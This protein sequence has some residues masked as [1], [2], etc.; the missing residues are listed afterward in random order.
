MYK[1][2]NMQSFFRINVQLY[3]NANSS[4]FQTNKIYFLTTKIAVY[5]FAR[6]SD[7]GINND[8][9]KTYDNSCAFI[10]H[11]LYS[12]FLQRFEILY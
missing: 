3:P 11:S 2:G 4:L 5:Y 1:I 6:L 8:E 12:T 10:V 9:L 7:F